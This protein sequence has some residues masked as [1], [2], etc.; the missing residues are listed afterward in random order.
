MGKAIV[1]D[2]IFKST[3]EVLD[4]CL[5]SDSSKLY[6]LDYS[7]SDQASYLRLYSKILNDLNWRVPEQN[8]MSA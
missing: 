7:S 3:G 6:V 5:S 2:V 4:C 8:S 1:Q